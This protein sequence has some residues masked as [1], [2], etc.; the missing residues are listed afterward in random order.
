MRSL[1]VPVSFSSL[2]RPVT[3]VPSEAGGSFFSPGLLSAGCCEGVRPGCAL[4]VDGCEGSC[5]RRRLAD[6]A[7]PK[8]K[9]AANN[10]ILWLRDKGFPFQSSF[11]CGASRGTKRLIYLIRN[12]NPELHLPESLGNLRQSAPVG[13]NCFFSPV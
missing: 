4:E 10:K 8:S 9:K 11:G 13:L 7:L 5:A 12:A 1:T 3:A 6:P 2:L